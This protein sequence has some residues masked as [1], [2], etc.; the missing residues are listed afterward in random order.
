M[1][2]AIISDIHSNLTALEAVIAD[3]RSHGI[4]HIMCL[5]NIIGL[6]PRPVECVDAVSENCFLSLLGNHDYSIVHRPVNCTYQVERGLS[7]ARSAI[8]SGPPEAASERWKYLE[9]L[10][11]RFDKNG[12][13]FVHGSP[14]DPVSEYLFPEDGVRN[15]RKLEECFRLF[16]K[17]LFVGHSQ[18][19]GV[20]LEDFSFTL[21][22][23]LEDGFHYEKGSKVIIS[24]GSVG[25]SRD[26]DP[27]ASYVEI[28]KN[29]M[30]WHRV[31]YD[32]ESVAREILE[33]EELASVYARRLREAY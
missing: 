23:K 20:F 25:Q 11:E 13:T 33:H 31:S 21:A 27:R 1:R 7:W 26:G 32:V 2:Y 29:D 24:V 9:G 17:V 28:N 30:T 19:P 10:P 6:G 4:K 12:I 8:E 16:E 14:R 15:Q 22:S 5:G 3:I 18:V